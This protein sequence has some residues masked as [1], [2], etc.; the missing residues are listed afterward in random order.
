MK[1]NYGRAKMTKADQR[2]LMGIV[3]AYMAGKG[4]GLPVP[5]YMGEVE[6]NKPAANTKDKEKRGDK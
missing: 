1:A 3:S 4:L 2:K 5:N 6:N